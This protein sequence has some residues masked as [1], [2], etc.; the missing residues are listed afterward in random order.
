MAYVVRGSV[1]V[2]LLM[3]SHRIL[4]AVAAAALAALADPLRALRV[5]LEE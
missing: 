4:M 1:E 5:V 2:L 3:A